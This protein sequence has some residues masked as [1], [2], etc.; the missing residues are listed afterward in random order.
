[1]LRPGLFRSRA[2]IIRARNQERLKSESLNDVSE[3]KTT[4]KLGSLQ[5]PAKIGQLT[6]LELG[7]LLAQVKTIKLPSF[8]VQT[9]FT[10]LLFK[11]DLL[12]QE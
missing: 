12:V 2:Y 6:Q 8:I 4:Q 10:Y 5:S 1:M 9:R 11:Q 7:L 3:P